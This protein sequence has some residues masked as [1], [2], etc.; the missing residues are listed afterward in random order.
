MLSRDF[1]NRNWESMDHRLRFPTLIRFVQNTKRDYFGNIPNQWRIRESCNH[2]RVLWH[3]RNNKSN[4]LSVKLP[5]VV[6]KIGQDILGVRTDRADDDHFSLLTCSAA[7][8]SVF[9]SSKLHTTIEQGCDIQT[10][11]KVWEKK[12][13]S[14]ETVR[15]RNKIK[16]KK[17]AQWPC[18][19]IGYRF[20]C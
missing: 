11:S 8:F 2:R 3:V 9:P 10:I 5:Q 14:S 19:N 18:P 13:W 16:T 17:A 20:V 12:I 1:A 6:L 7:K 4:G 15:G